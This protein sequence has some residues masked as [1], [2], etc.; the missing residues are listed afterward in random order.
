MAGT[1]PEVIKLAPLIR[2][3]NANRIAYKFV[4]TGQHNEIALDLLDWFE[5]RLDQNLQVEFTSFLT[6][7]L[8]KLLS[9]FEKKLD[10]N[11]YTGMI[12]Q[13]DTTT[14]LA[15]A[16]WAFFNK[17]PFYHVEAGLRCETPYLPFPEEINR[18]LITQIASINF[19]PTEKAAENLRNEGIPEDRIF[20]VGNT[21]VDSFMFS[22]KKNK[23]SQAKEI[24]FENVK[25]EFGRKVLVTAH[26]RESI[27]A[28]LIEICRAIKYL[29]KETDIKFYWPVHP[30]PAIKEI[31]NKELASTHNVI[32]MS[33]LRY[34]QIISLIDKVDFVISDSGGLQEECAAAGVPIIILRNETEREEI[35]SEGLGILVGTSFD[36]ITEIA[37]NF[38][39]TSKG[40]VRT[41]SL[42]FGDGNTSSKIIEIIKRVQ[43]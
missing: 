35:V 5:I 27:G 4:L 36:K 15:A 12:S 3:L 43:R 25:I 2:S 24:L 1:R 14:A 13:G 21:V 30:N 42:V 28:P 6:L 16:M 17:I 8:S 20:M 34:Q 32:L 26:R 38:I 37:M 9:S 31:I 18:R 29:A 23:E 11:E 39:N 7:N 22:R 10:A 33:P 41:P 40:L 19:C